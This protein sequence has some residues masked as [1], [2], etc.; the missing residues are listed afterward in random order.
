MNGVLKELVKNY[1]IIFVNTISWQPEVT[2]YFVVST[3]PRQWCKLF[4]FIEACSLRQKF[5]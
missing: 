1:K 4:L 3:V 5:F 2:T